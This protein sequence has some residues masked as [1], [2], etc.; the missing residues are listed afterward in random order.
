MYH[1]VKGKKSGQN[2]IQT[3]PYRLIRHPQNFGILLIALPFA[4]YIPGLNDL[5][6]RIGEILSWTL[7]GLILIIYSDI[8]EYKLSKKFPEEFSNYQVKTGFF[9]PKLNFRKSKN[10]KPIYYRKRYLFLLLGYILLVFT[11]FILTNFLTTLG[12]FIIYL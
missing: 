10:D 12:I 1:L 5:G 4:L 6:I 2:I 3:G 8:E 11:V 7:F 9:Y